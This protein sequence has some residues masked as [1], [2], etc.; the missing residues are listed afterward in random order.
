M[1]MVHLRP[2]APSLRL[3]AAVELVISSSLNK[4]FVLVC[5]KNLLSN[6]DSNQ[7][8]TLTWTTD[9]ENFR[10]RVRR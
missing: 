5:H 8:T 3:A 9:T 2:T 4:G 1:S 10:A 6:S 7:Q